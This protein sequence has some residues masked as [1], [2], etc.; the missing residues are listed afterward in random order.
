M[1][2]RE[3]HIPVVL[4]ICA[5][6]LLHYGGGEQSDRLAALHDAKVRL[7]IAARELAEPPTP[8]L[9]VDTLDF[10]ALDPGAEVEPEAKPPTEE[11]PP[12]PS[13]LDDKKKKEEAKSPVAP[14]TKP[15]VTAPAVQE[16][17][18]ETKVTVV[19]PVPPTPVAPP[20]PPPSTDK[21]IAVQQHQD[22]DEEKNDDAKYLAEKN[23]KVKPED[24][25]HATITST[26]ENSKDP[27]PG[28][29]A[30]SPDH[31]P[32]NGDKNQ[33]AHDT[34]R[35][36]E[37]V[38]P[39]VVPKS[40]A[41]PPSKANPS[42]TPGTKNGDDKKLALGPKEP[43]SVAGHAPQKTSEGKGLTSP[44]PGSPD[45][46]AGAGGTYDVPTASSGPMGASSSKVPTGSGDGKAKSLPTLPMPGAPKWVAGLGAGYQGEG[47]NKLSLNEKI[48]KAVIGQDEL[49]RL[50]KVEGE[51]K[52]SIHR[53]AWKSSSLEKWRSAIENYTP[54]VKAGN[55]TNLATAAAPWATYLSQ[56][57][58]RL[59]PIFADG[60]VEGLGD[61]P[62]THPLNDKT[63]VTRMEIVMKPDGSLHHLGIVKPSGNTAFDVAALDAVDRAAPFGKAPTQI[64]SP[65]GLVYLHWEFHRDD[66]RCSNVNAYPYLLK[67]GG[68]PKPIEPGEPPKAKPPPEAE[69]KLGLIPSK[70]FGG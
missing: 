10:V 15:P 38:S 47:G 49:D 62:A 55:Q 66:Q 13:L 48:T 12:E 61:L 17:K 57:H 31:G 58:V 22:K 44:G 53:G 6:A 37:K 43:P 34:D 59:H 40:A 45:L 46:V 4:W 19:V 23:H 52:L 70:P 42:P 68:T 50:K 51:T 26:T 63:L 21:K 54:G 29:H 56:I 60:F 3:A 33:V 32:G 2:L 41:V 28:T 64:V 69:K 25:T 24:Q 27:N 36:G 5:A 67:E 1:R 18:N 9:E 39:N 14:P 11:T 65:D 35:P 7:R 16:K 20:P 8:P 30:G